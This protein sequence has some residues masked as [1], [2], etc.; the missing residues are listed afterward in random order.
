M[1]SEENKQII[2][3]K[4]HALRFAYFEKLRAIKIAQTGLFSGF[5]SL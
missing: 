4:N 3:T 5:S 1:K 2:N